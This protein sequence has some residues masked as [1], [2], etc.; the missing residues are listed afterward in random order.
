MATQP[1]RPGLEVLFDPPLDDALVARLTRLWT[2]VANAGGAVGFVPGVTEADIVP[3]ASAAFARVRDGSAR[4]V[5]AYE[6]VDPIG[7]AF[8]EHR[9]GP[10][11]RHWVT[12]KRLQVA[13]HRQGQG[14][15][16]AMLEAITEWAVQSGLEQIHL[17][18]RGGTGT[19]TFYERFGYKVVARIPGVIRL[20]KGHTVEEIYMVKRIDRHD[21]NAD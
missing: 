18:V 17:T 11:F 5:I 7:L 6:S 16:A 2:E 14:I 15:G 20:A 1:E 19:E 12:V 8:L 21:T 4:L 3:V 13:P 9:P 10:L